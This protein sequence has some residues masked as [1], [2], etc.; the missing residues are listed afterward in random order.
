MSYTALW[1]L[2]LGQGYGYTASL[3]S[4]NLFIRWT[5]LMSHLS[6]NSAWRSFTW[7]ERWTVQH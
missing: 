7:R 5:I 4:L 2:G 1:D 6:L 3:D